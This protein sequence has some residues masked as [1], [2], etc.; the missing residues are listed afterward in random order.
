MKIGM[1]GNRTGIENP[2]LNS[3]RRYIDGADI[4]EAHHGDCFGADTIFHEIMQSRNIS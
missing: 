3:F 2:A 1:T 4:V